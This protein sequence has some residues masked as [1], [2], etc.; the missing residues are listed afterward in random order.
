MLPGRKRRGCLAGMPEKAGTDKGDQCEKKDKNPG[1]AGCGDRAL[2]GHRRFFED[3]PGCAASGAAAARP[4]RDGVLR[5]SRHSA[6]NGADGHFAA[7]NHGGAGDHRRAGNYGR[8]HGSFRR[9]CPRND[10]GNHP[11]NHSGRD[12]GD[13]A[14]GDREAPGA[15]RLG[16]HR[17]DGSPDH[18]AGTGDSHQGSE[19]VRQGSQ[20]L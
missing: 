15:D 7:G 19:T 6:G 8:S 20:L 5:G 1:S 3:I 13:E 10:R 11:G 4:R 18:R 14:P 16:D 17:G 12:S 2:P 9:D